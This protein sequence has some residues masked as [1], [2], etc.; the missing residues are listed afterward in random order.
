MEEASTC[1]RSLEELPV[2]SEGSAG[3]AK[4]AAASS[5]APRT[6]RGERAA[7]AALGQMGAPP[8]DL[9]RAVPVSERS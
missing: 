7:L 3:Q 1:V 4:E 6:R 8:G 5:C 2:S 9:A